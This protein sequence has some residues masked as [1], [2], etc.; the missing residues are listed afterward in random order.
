MQEM[1]AVTPATQLRLGYVLDEDGRIRSTREP[2]P[3]PGPI[4]TLIRSAS[5]CAW[6]IRA[7]VPGELAAE[8]DRLAGEE[9][10]VQDPRARPLHVDAYL[11]LVGGQ[12]ESG[13]AFTFPDEIP[14]LGDVAP[15]D[16]LQLLERNF[17]GW[18][19][20]E[21]PGRS[22]ILAVIE[23]GYPVSVCFCA[24]SA[25]TAAEAGL[26]TAAAFRGRGFAP[27]VTA[28]WATAIR[29]SGRIP[30]YSTSWGNAASLA[31]ARKLG[32]VQYATDWS[33]GGT[34]GT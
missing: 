4:F 7:D 12:V 16:S 9:P 28:A 14:R 29:S 21:I 22:P 27:R 10:P 24:R 18:T 25:E 15:V 19:A 23:G 3:T 30:L 6:A 11:S 5:S 13:P 17:R 2:E 26:E 31:V 8:L 20:A 32:L 1:N 33:L 34:L